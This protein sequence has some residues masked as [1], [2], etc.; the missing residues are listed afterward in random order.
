MLA[1][2][3]FAMHD[4]D[5][6]PNMLTATLPFGGVTL[7]EYQA[8]LL[9][10]AGASQ[11]IIVV[12]RLTPELLGAINRIGKRGIAVDTVRTAAEAAET[13]HPLARVLMLADGLTTTGD[14]LAVLARE[15]GDALLVVPE[16]QVGPGY[17][18][19]GGGMVWAGVGWNRVAS[20]SWRRCPA[21]M[22]CLRPLSASRRRPGRRISCCRKRRFARAMASVI[23]RRRSTREAGARWRRWCRRAVGGSNAM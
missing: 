13:L 10:A 3:L 11:I 5:D 17:E 22:T 8:R 21:T 14:T 16:D 23:P 4:A 7:I 18:R 15:G 20:P 19:L 6:R 12:A 1:G 2:L 9:I